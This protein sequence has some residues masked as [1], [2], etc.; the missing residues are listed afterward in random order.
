MESRLEPFNEAEG[1]YMRSRLP[2][3]GVLLG[4]GVIGL[5]ACLYVTVSQ[6]PDRAYI[7]L[8]V[9]ILDLAATFLLWRIFRKLRSDARGGMKKVVVAKVTEKIERGKNGPWFL[10][11]D[12]KSYRVVPEAYTQYRKGEKIE[13]YSSPAAGIWL[14]FGQKAEKPAKD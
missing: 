13:V 2:M 7:Y 12:R 4:F 8:A 1:M 9:L 6:W 11:V 5:G 3:P 14:G 10:V